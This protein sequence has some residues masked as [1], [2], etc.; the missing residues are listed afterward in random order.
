L[1]KQFKDQGGAATMNPSGLFR[2]FSSKVITRMTSEKILEKRR[3]QAEK[4]RSKRGLRHQI[5]YFHQVDDG[6]S[7]LAA[8]LLQPLL[9]NYDIELVTHLVSGPTGNNLPEPE[10]LLALSRY[11]SQQIAPHYGLMFPE[12]EDSPRT[13]QVRLA[14][15]ILANVG[16]ADFPLAASAIG[17]AL[18][19]GLEEPL[20]S[21]AKRYGCANDAETNSRKAAG[22]AHRTELKHY[23][24]AMFYYA[25]EWY[26]GVDRFY[27]LEQRLIDLGARLDKSTVPLYPRPAIDL[28]G[29][30]DTKSLTLE[31]YPSLRSPYTAVIFQ[32]TLALANES[33]IALK[34]RPVLPMVMR[35]VPAT[36]E[37]GLYIFKD[38]AREAR[39]LGLT[40][41]TK[42]YDPIGD[43]V[44]KCY[45][46][47][48][49]AREQNREVQ[50]LAC[51]LRAAFTDG[52]NTN[53][54]HGMRTVVENAGLCWQEAKQRMGGSEMDAELELNR[55]AMYEFGSWGVPS[56]RLL[57][58]SGN[59]VLALWGQ[60]RL[61]LFAREIKRLLTEQ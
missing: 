13:E 60:D 22:T 36:R 15:S 50:L 31:F 14:E 12:G 52:V 39:A 44:S 28:G 32:H 24:G 9:D 18:W 43:P 61:W 4:L 58:Q 10:L 33:G 54:E 40:W 47:Y 38:A 48:P 25:G 57:D 49:W 3:N 34:V 46:L 29:V 21:L 23:S 17:E 56:F 42:V 11:D 19:S 45:S 37:K 6:Y 27:H 1:S 26:W 30:K 8:Q 53:S 51:F 59:T 35:G 7:H 41:G 16:Q 20:D 55:L 5:D 2:W